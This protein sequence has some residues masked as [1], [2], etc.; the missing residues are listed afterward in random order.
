MRLLRLLVLIVAS[1]SFSAAVD[2]QQKN[3][4]SS[5]LDSIMEL[6]RK[7][8]HTKLSG[9]QGFDSATAVLNQHLATFAEPIDRQEILMWIAFYKRRIG[10]Y[11]SSA[12]YIQLLK[13]ELDRIPDVPDSLLFR[14]YIYLVTTETRR[15][16]LS[17][18]LRLLPKAIELASTDLE[19]SRVYNNSG[20]VYM[21]LDDYEQ[22]AVYYKKDYD[23][24]VNGNQRR[25]AHAAFHLGKNV[26][27][28][29]GLDS[30]WYWFDRTMMHRPI[31]MI[32]FQI[33]LHQV[34]RLVNRGQPAAGL[35]TLLQ[36]E[37]TNDIINRGSRIFYWELM[38]NILGDNQSLIVKAQTKYPGL[39]HLIAYDSCVS[40]LSTLN[41]GGGEVNRMERYARTFAEHGDLGRAYKA[42]VL[43]N[44]IASGQF[45][46]KVENNLIEQNQLERLLSEQAILRKEVQLDR[47]RTTLIFALL[48]SAVLALFLVYFYLNRQKL[49]VLNKQLS[50]Q[51]ADILSQQQQIEEQS[52]QLKK[53]DEMKSR[54]FINISH[55]LRTPLTLIMGSTEHTMK[56]KHGKI[57]D[58]IQNTLQ[59]AFRNS[60]RL[61]RMVND[62]LDLSKLEHGK[63]TMKV[64]PV[65]I[66]SLALR[67][68]DIFRS[69][70]SSVDVRFE[71]QIE[72]DLPSLPA[73]EH[74]IESVFMNLLGNALRFSPQGETIAV[75][76]TQENGHVKFTVSDKGI[77]IPAEDLPYVFDRFFQVEGKQ[78]S[79]GSGVGLT[80]AKEIVDLHEG[81]IEVQSQPGEGTTF[82]VM[83]PYRAIE[84]TDEE[85]SIFATPD[86]PVP[87]NEGEN[88]TSVVRIPGQ[89]TLLVVEDHPEMRD[90]IEALLRPHFTL[91]LAANGQLA[92]EVLNQRKVDLILTDYMMP[93]MDGVAFVKAI[94][95]DNRWKKIPTIFLTARAED[96]DKLQV[97]G[98]GVDDY[99]VKPFLE[100]ELL[101]RINNLLKLQNERA[102]FAQEDL[103][104]QK[105]QDEFLKS[106]YSYVQNKLGSGNLTISEMSDHLSI[107]ERT[108]YRKIKGQTGFTPEQYIKE[109][110]LLEARK[111]LERR[112]KVSISDVAFAVGFESV[113]HFSSSYKKRFGHP[114]SNYLS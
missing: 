93:V 97:L 67:C 37:G 19:K 110:R 25:A 109:I 9:K 4:Y 104:A 70:A 100:D 61:L 27:R 49:Q 90:Y 82:S 28:L 85:E 74:K 91:E 3:E 73:D 106:I 81:K 102:E 80:L 83:L 45:E 64:Q 94:K 66:S 40:I 48:I 92:L 14:Y 53:L 62:I 36:L 7:A 12:Y 112:E 89:F 21:E 76:L 87:M 2:A 60:Q 22:A 72:R 51:N 98:H 18:A 50:F 23:L 6:N 88:D 59:T 79:E 107:S 47:Q 31:P 38:A 54:F 34:R 42:S 58:R 5:R 35:D 57:N 78:S 24:M 33:K 8:V 95:R 99:L 32:A 75:T 103:G 29:F 52:I 114:P 71:A 39:N 46:E 20:L 41:I 11:D 111:L 1:V 113:S 13:Q 63:L 26:N 56:G 43:A 68:V 77:G 65:D 16:N 55:E 108:L 30:A 96:Q 15:D 101:L 69:K 17:D 86:L 44:E 84:Y 105:A 10:Q